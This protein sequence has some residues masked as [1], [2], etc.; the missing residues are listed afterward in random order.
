MNSLK[1]IRSSRLVEDIAI[2]DGQPGCGKTLFSTIC[3]YL[4]RFEVMKYSSHIEN[5]L[6]LKDLDEISLSTCQSLCEIEL[7]LLLYESMM[8]RNVNFRYKDLSSVFRNKKFFIYLK[9]IFSRGDEF[10][11]EQIRLK[12]PILN[13][14][15]HNLL[16]YLDPLFKSYSHRLKL[17]EVVR[18][19]LY[20]IIQMSLNY[21]TLEKTNG[22]RFFY[23][24]LDKNKEI[25]PFW[26]QDWD[27]YNELNNVEKAIH[28]IFFMTKK[29]EDFKK[30]NPEASV[31]TIPFEKFV[32]Q[33]YEFIEEIKNFFDTDFIR[34]IK[35]ILKDQNVPRLKVADGI[36]EEVYKRCGWVP[37][38]D[39]LNEK[40][41]LIKRRDFAINQKA[42]DFS[43]DLLDY[44]SS[45]Y[46]EKYNF[47]END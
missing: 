18:H 7:D 14:C 22:S 26:A 31:L 21:E 37:S 43:M 23:I 25:I 11:P 17:L 1:T 24:H 35:K 36:P 6:A 39:G 41:E 44:L 15:T 4:E 3:S 8:S 28:E 34:P 2:I 13:L 33:P 27:K 12:K 45:S 46:E 19:P 5:Y 42:S 38:E 10:V 20:Q 9:R 30:R 16:G 29:S 40:Q 32:K 47:L